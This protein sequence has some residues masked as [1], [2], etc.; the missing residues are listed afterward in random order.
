MLYAAAYLWDYYAKQTA[1]THH[2]QISLTQQTT[3][4]EAN[5]EI[6]DE[7]PAEHQCRDKYVYRLIAV[8]WLKTVDVLMFRTRFCLLLFYLQH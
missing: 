4:K 3:Y 6:S 2:Q 7:K 1:S 5:T 8:V